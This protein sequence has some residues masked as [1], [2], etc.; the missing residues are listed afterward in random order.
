VNPEHDILAVVQQFDLPGE[1]RRAAPFGSGH[2]HD[3]WKV[4]F[5]RDGCDTRCILQRINHSI[6]TNPAA[7]ME[8]IRRVTSHI[9]GKLAGHPDAARRVLTLVPTSEGRTWYVAPD[10]NHWRAYR[11]IEG[12]RTRDVP[13]SV[14]QAFEA[15]RA[16]GQFQSW[17]GDL[18][19]P[20]LHDTIPDFHNTPKRVDALEQAIGTDA[21][22]RAALAMREIAF[23]LQRKA[24][25]GVLIDADLPE[26]V[27]HN[28]TKFNN[29]LLDDVTG[30]GLCVL[31]LDTVMP[32]L[33]LYDFGDMVRSTAC[34]VRED[35]GNAAEARM[36][37]ALFEA[38]VRGY[39]A[40]MGGLLTRAERE[41]LALAGKVIALELGVRFLTDFLSGDVYFRVQRQGQNLDRARTQFRLVESMEA[42]EEQ[43]M[44]LVERLG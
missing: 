6:F 38:L 21:L 31:D 1:P 11:F 3:T 36:E 19:A 13:E 27:T 10:G 26:R 12:C 42:Q 24:G 5:T 9:A 40:A 7:V 35:A 44:R 20:R 23:A 37:M 43:M 18:P 15:A 28:D 29:V 16:F 14:Q 30:E 41:L 4:T 22:N 17:L 33:A 2:I 25:A 8:N 39:L 34:R 32:G